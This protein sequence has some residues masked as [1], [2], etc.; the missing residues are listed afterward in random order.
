MKQHQ[1]LKALLQSELNQPPNAAIMN[2]YQQC[3]DRDKLWAS[4]KN[5]YYQLF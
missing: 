5:I 1:H 2:L 4:D 3:Q